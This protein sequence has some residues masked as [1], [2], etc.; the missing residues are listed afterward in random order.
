RRLLYVAAT[1]ARERLI[2]AESQRKDRA[3]Q[4]SFGGLLGAWQDAAVIERRIL[5]P[6]P[7]TA[8]P[9]PAASGDPPA[10]LARTLAAAQRAGAPAGTELGRPSGLAGED[11]LVPGERDESLPP[12]VVTAQ[13]LAQAVGT[14]LHEVLERWSWRDAQH[15][16][17]LLRGA[18]IRAA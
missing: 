16:R 3:R 2:F 8:P 1:R 14:A 7:G 5:E 11:E 15:A 4:N 9:G 6:A 17:S 13:K 18:V 10:A 12:R